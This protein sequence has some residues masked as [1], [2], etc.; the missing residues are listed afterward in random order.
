MRD[1]FLFLCFV[2]G[3]QSFSQNVI[4]LKSDEKVEP[5]TIGTYLKGSNLYVLNFEY[6]DSDNRFYFLYKIDLESKKVLNKIK[7]NQGKIYKEPYF[8]EFND[9]LCIFN[10]S[11]FDEFAGYF[12]FDFDLNTQKYLQDSNIAEYA[13][14][15]KILFFNDF[16]NELIYLD[17][18]PIKKEKG[19]AYLS[20]EDKSLYFF[21][22]SY[23][24][25]NVSFNKVNLETNL[26]KVYTFKEL[27]NYENDFTQYNKFRNNSNFF[28]SKNYIFVTPELGQAVNLG[29]FYV[30]K[31]NKTDASLVNIE[32]P[33]IENLIE[34][35]KIKIFLDVQYAIASGG[36]KDLI[37]FGVDKN[38]TFC[39]CK[40]KMI[41]ERFYYH[42]IKNYKQ[43][44]IYIGNDYQTKSTK[45]YFD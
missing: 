10:R 37:Q 40:S 29:N 30:L 13:K 36:K 14:S 31:F 12:I 7:I 27:P 8:K 35:D 6:L 23:Q 17:G 3:F 15:N 41:E 21:E 44:N 45:V 32:I 42:Y 2:F 16:K 19:F 39:I 25:K 34:C 43:K 24:T 11:T 9:S 20:L 5:E 18:K 33:K 22:P 38:Q 26:K 4:E 28:A 1:F